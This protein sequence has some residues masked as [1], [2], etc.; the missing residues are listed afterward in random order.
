MCAALRWVCIGPILPVPRLRFQNIGD[1]IYAPNA[2]RFCLCGLD[3]PCSDVRTRPDTG[4]CGIRQPHASSSSARSGCNA[5][6]IRSEDGP[7][8]T[9][10]GNELAAAEFF[11]R[12]SVTINQS[13]LK[14]PVAVPLLAVEQ[15]NACGIAPPAPPPSPTS[16]PS[17]IAPECL[18]TAITLQIPYELTPLPR[19]EERRV[20]KE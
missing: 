16:T 15:L 18:L 6:R 14:Q 19:S 13:S 2:S 10:E 7:V 1:G 17:S 5:V 9:A 8:A 11:G 12:I 20:G 3:E 4:G